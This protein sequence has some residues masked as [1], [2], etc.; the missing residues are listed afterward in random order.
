MK[1]SPSMP[2][3]SQRA[4]TT[5]DAAAPPEF[6]LGTP[7]VSPHHGVGRIVERGVRR[8]FGVEREYLTVE[9]PRGGVRLMIPLDQVGHGAGLRRVASPSTL[10]AALEIL[11]T[12]PAALSGTWQTRQQ[13]ISRRLAGGDTAL[14]AEVVRDYAHAASAKPLATNDRALYGQVRGLVEAELEVGLDLSPGEAAAEI[15][16]RVPAGECPPL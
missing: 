9:I 7:V 16:S 12:S 4:A 10:R 2:R 5:A 1:P 11:A 15:D 3:A 14:L 13:D 8:L 6:A